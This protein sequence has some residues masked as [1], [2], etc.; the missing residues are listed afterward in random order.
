MDQKT[1]GLKMGQSKS[2]YLTEPLLTWFEE[3]NESSDNTR[4]ALVNFIIET[5]IGI[6]HLNL[7]ENQIEE[8]KGLPAD[9]RETALQ[10]MSKKPAIENN[11]D[12]PKATP[13]VEESLDDIKLEDTK[14]TPKES[15]EDN[16]D[17]CSP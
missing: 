13:P 2:I 9:L 12:K 7:T 11:V 16:F 14:E 15:F 8:L 6:E 10:N 1:G 17:K 3:V 5:R 4:K